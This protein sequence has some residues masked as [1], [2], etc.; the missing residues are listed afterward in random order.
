MA[1]PEALLAA[2]RGLVVAPAGCGKTH[3]LAETVKRNPEGRI[4][5]LTHTRA[6]VAVIK[7]RLAHIPNSAYRVATLDTWSAWLA[8]G[9]PETSG[10]VPTGTSRDYDLAKQAA[11]RLLR[12]CPIRDLLAATYSRVLVDEYQD[13]G[14]LQHCLVQAIAEAVPTIVLGDPMQAI[15]DFNGKLPDWDGVERCFET[16]WTLDTPYRWVN[17]HEP[18]FGRWILDR[19]TDLQRGG[20]IDFRSFPANVRWVKLSENAHRHGEEQLAAIPSPAPR[21][22]VLVING[23]KGMHMARRRREIARRSVRLSVVE[24][25]ELPELREWASRIEAADGIGRVRTILDFAHEVMTGVDVDSTMA[26]L[27]VLRRGSERKAATPE[28]RALLALADDRSAGG[29]ASILDQLK[30]GRTVFRPDLRDSVC[31]AC[32]MAAG[33]RSL[34]DAARMVQ[35]RR[36]EEGRRVEPRAIGS[37]LLLKGLEADHAV[38]LDADDMKPTDLYVAISR[39]SKGLTVVSRSPVLPV[40]STFVNRADHAS[41]LGLLI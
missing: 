3:L 39:A 4:L 22:T 10:F 6:G 37:T 34:V 33:G 17:A 29:V 12:Q 18:A 36:A 28:E 7:N 11:I 2:R 35:A 27:D 24:N 25:A 20:R 1:T 16:V 5:V 23:K 41:A 9:F 8:K 32:R 14:V 40:S 30:Y 26:R 21:T 15:F 38:V 13:C 31:Q 19:R